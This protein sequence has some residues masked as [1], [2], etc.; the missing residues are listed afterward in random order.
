LDIHF[1]ISFLH[2]LLIL[3]RPRSPWSINLLPLRLGLPL[4]QLLVIA[5]RCLVATP[6]SELIPGNLP[7]IFAHRIFDRHVVRG[8]DRLEC[9]QTRPPHDDIIGRLSPYNHKSHHAHLPQLSRSQCH[10][11][12]DLSHRHDFSPIKAV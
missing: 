10:G 5:D 9:I 8:Y 7:Y 6:R 12:T 11:Q 3:L 1:L 2:S 4:R